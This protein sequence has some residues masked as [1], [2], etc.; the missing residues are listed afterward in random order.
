MST[1]VPPHLTLPNALDDFM[2][3]VQSA[4]HTRYGHP[5]VLPLQESPLGP[6]AC[7]QGMSGSHWRP[8]LQQA[9]RV[10]LPLEQGFEHALHEDL[11]HWYG[12]YWSAGIDVCFEGEDLHLLQIW[13]AE[14]LQCL[15]EN[16]L[17][18]GFARRRNRLPPA[19]F[20]GLGPQD[21]VMCIDNAS[22][23]ITLEHPGQAPH[24]ELAPSAAHLLQG[25]TPIVE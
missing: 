7:T 6:S 25:C 3:R 9:P 20:I 19:F 21:T 17:G 10:L 16:Q 12:R 1:D 5:P 18:H 11:H 8:A 24:R 13:N 4:W 15:L 2:E 23:A 14:D 22:G